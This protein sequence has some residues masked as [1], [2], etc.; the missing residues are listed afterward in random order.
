M[1]LN[2]LLYVRFIYGKASSGWQWWDRPF[3]PALGTP[4][5]YH[6]VFSVR[7]FHVF[8]AQGISLAQLSFTSFRLSSDTYFLV[9]GSFGVM[10]AKR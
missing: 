10:T 8:F 5:K 2:V 7:N 6:S 4:M 3:V 1:T 9:V